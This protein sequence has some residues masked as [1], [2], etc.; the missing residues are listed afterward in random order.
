MP[1]A[2]TTGATQ[3]FIGVQRDRA[4]YNAGQKQQV[5]DAAGGLIQAGGDAVQRS[6]MKQHL[7]AAGIDEGTADALVRAGPAAATKAL[8]QKNAEKQADM[9]ARQVAGLLTQDGLP[10]APDIGQTPP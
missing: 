5:M 10:T 7:L 3:N 8:I 2:D 6:Q 1:I 4:A 9:E